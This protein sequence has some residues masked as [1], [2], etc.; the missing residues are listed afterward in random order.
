MSPFEITADFA[1]V[2]LHGPGGKY[3]GLYD[4]KALANW[5]DRISSWPVKQAWVYFDN[6]DSGFAP[7]NARELREL[8]VT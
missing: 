4:K 2:R 8:T 7:R 1:Y 5:A 6:D 3:Q